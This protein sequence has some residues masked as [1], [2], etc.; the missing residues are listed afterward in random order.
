MTFVLIIGLGIQGQKRSAV[1]KSQ[2]I[3]FITLDPF[4]KK[5]NYNNLKKIKIIII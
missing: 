2:K 4:N 1:L 3:K 5:A